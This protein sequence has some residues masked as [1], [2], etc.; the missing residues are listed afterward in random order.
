MSFLKNHDFLSEHKQALKKFVVNEQDFTRSRKLGLVHTV[1]HILFQALERNLNGYEITSQN[2][3]SQFNCIES[4]AARSS[5]CEARSKINW[6]AFAYLLTQLN[7]ESTSKLSHLKW[8][9]HNVKAIDGTFLT[10]PA[11]DEVLK[12]YP[13][14]KKVKAHYPNGLLV[15]AMNVFTG[16]P[17]CAV[18]SNDAGSER[19]SLN[20]LLN[21]FETNDVLLLDRGYEGLE[22]FDNIARRN[23]FFIARIRS[24][25]EAKNRVLKKFNGAKWLS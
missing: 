5:F 7:Q 19:A 24:T 11:T 14:R 15:T 17:V 4:A 13:R 21:K 6:Q 18:F 22:H 23:L 8:R 9:G 2:Y 25:G 12:E 20:K 1:G 3:F 16:Q 10:L